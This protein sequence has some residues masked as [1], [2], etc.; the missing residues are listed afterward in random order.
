MSIISTKKHFAE[1]QIEELRLEIAHC[2]L[3]RRE[4]RDALKELEW[5]QE[6]IRIDAEASFFAAIEREAEQWPP[7]A[8]FNLDQLPF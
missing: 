3:T 8:S 5:L 7:S 6:Q 2:H 1:Q 4:R